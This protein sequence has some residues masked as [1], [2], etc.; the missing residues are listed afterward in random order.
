VLAHIG[1]ARL[2][3][4]TLARFRG[5][6]LAASGYPEGV[7]EGGAAFPLIVARGSGDG[8]A[9][10]A[11]GGGAGTAHGEEARGGWTS[12]A[13]VL[14]RARAVLQKARKACQNVASPQRVARP[15]QDRDGNAKASTK[16]RIDL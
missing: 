1:A 3:A 2:A 8:G 12:P 9:G 16:R 15:L 10:A 6:E 14:S 4:D 11:R 13:A 5:G 7:A